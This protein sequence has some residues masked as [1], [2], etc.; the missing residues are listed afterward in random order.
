MNFSEMTQSIYMEFVAM[1]MWTLLRQR[2]LLHL[3]ECKMTPAITIRHF[4]PYL[5]RE[6]FVLITVRIVI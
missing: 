1:R 3:I 5:K 2:F 4:L 6:I